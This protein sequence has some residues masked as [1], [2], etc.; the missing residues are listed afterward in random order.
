M[1]RTDRDRCQTGVDLVN[2]RV[3]MRWWS[4]DDAREN[5]TIARAVW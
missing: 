3:M 5:V 2:A 4:R 1:Q